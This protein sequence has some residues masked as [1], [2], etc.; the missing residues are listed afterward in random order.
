MLSLTRTFCSFNSLVFYAH[1]SAYNCFKM[2]L[3][4]AFFLLIFILK[5][6]YNICEQRFYPF[7]CHIDKYTVFD[8]NYV[9]Y[10]QRVSKLS[11][12]FHSY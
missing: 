2:A 3:C 9:L 12:R 11:G 8:V 7:N 10:I 4:S 6:R 5:I 1:S